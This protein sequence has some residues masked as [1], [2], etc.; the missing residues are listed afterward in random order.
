MRLGHDPRR[1]AGPAAAPARRPGDDARR[2]RGR[3]KAGPPA[4]RARPLQARVDAAPAGRPSS[5]S[6]P[7]TYRGDL[8]VDR[9]VTLVGRGRPRLVGLGHAAA[10]S[11]SAPPT[12]RS[13]ASTS[14]AAAAAISAATPPASTSPRRDATI[15]DCR[16]PRTRSSASTCARPTAPSVERCRIR[17]IPG[18][19]PG[20]KGS[21]IHV[22]NTERLPPRRQRD[23][24]RA[25]RLLHPVL[26]ARR[27]SAATWPATCATASTTCSRTTTSSRTT[28]SR[29]APP[30]PRSC[31][32]SGS[33]SAATASSTTAAS[34]RW[35]CCFK[36]CDDVLAEDNL[37]ADNARGIFLEG[38]YRN[39][40]P[41][42]RHRRAPTWRVVLYD[43]CGDNRF[44]GNSFVGNLTP[45]DPRR[46]AHRH[47]SSTATTGPSNDEP[48][49][50]GDGRSDR[51][52]RLSERLRPLP[53]QPDRGRPLHAEPRRL[54]A[55][56]P[57]S[58]RSRCSSRSRSRT[59]RPLARPP[60]LPD[61]PR[62]TRGPSAAATPRAMAACARRALGLG[63]AA[64]LAR[65]RR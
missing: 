40:L 30:A 19:D 23:R 43:S 20:E 17:G 37:I 54:G 28:S 64:V 55:A 24:G 41:R 16:D 14:T 65:G 3:S 49:L 1:A 45:L 62:P 31:T 59:A 53:R 18:K 27:R 35:A 13:R 48:D 21:G 39:T 25:R 10:S 56:A 52:Y 60:A 46:P 50:D 61:V 2:R 57:P 11:A 9:R 8:F 29:T 4:G 7:A 15:R 44:E 5:R 36:A 34:P 26:V 6:G 58:G 33:S 42:Q 12:S 38:S 32:R 51:P 22:W 63:G 47:A